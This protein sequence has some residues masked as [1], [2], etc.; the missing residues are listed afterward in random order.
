MRDIHRVRGG[1]TG[2]LRASRGEGVRAVAAQY[3]RQLPEGLGDDAPAADAKVARGSNGWSSSAVML[4][5]T[6]V[7]SGPKADRSAANR[8][9]PSSTGFTQEKAQC[10]SSTPPG[11]TPGSSSCRVTWLLG[12]H[13]SL[14]VVLFIP[15]KPGNSRM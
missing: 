9:G 5:I 14:H 3:A 11:C 2:S 8:S 12:I 4:G 6:S 7:P 1:D 15:G 13:C 10:T